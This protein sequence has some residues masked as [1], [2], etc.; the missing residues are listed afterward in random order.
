MFLRDLDRQLETLLV[1]NFSQRVNNEL[2]SLLYVL[3]APLRVCLATGNQTVHGEV[4]I[5]SSQECGGVQTKIE[6]V[7][8]DDA[9]DGSWFVDVVHVVT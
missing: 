9:L 5:Q 7:V 8:A 3:D 1:S 6:R 4:D 2:L